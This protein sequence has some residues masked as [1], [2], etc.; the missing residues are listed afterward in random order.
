M[1]WQDMWLATG[2]LTSGRR[3][4]LRLYHSFL[5]AFAL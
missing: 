4:K 1:S 2:A 5:L 3:S